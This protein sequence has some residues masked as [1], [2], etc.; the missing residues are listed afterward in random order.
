MTQSCHSQLESAWLG[1]PC[2]LVDGGFYANDS[3]KGQ[4]WRDSRF[5]GEL[6]GLS[7]SSD[8]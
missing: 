1:Q 3:S 5:E 6:K 2:Q 7:E 4:I 8:V